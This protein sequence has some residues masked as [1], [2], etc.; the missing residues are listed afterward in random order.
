MW[1][2][3]GE[4]T[5]PED[6]TILADTGALALGLANAAIIVTSSTGLVVELVRRNA[7]ND[8]DVQKQ[9]LQISAYVPFVISG[10][11][12]GLSMNQRVLLR[13]RGSGTVG[14]VQGSIFS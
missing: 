1:V 11:P 9:P 7:A 14:V 5:D 3:A 13:V 6:E 4:L 8:A 12:I 10:L 2:S